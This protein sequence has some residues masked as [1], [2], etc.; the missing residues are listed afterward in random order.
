MRSVIGC[1]KIGKSRIRNLPLKFTRHIPQPNLMIQH[2]TQHKLPIGTIPHKRNG[3][4]PLG[5]NRLETFTRRHVPYP[6]QPIVRGADDART[7]S[8]K[9]DAGD[10]I[11]VCGECGD[12]FSRSN[13]PYFDGFVEGAG[14]EEVSLG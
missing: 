4:I 11:G 9:V 14:Y 13:V 1:G 12:A 2:P 8:I 3:R 7:V 6:N 5:I 10:G